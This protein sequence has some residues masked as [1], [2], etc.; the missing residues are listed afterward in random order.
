MKKQLSTL[1]IFCVALGAMAQ[2]ITND[3]H[4]KYSP[5]DTVYGIDLYGALKDIPKPAT[6]KSVIVAVIDNGVDIKHPDLVTN[7]WTNTF[8]IPGNSV[9]DD[10][11]GYIDD[12]HGWD[13]LGNV[14]GD[15]RYDNL[16]M[17]R[18]LRELRKKYDGK[19]SKEI[20]KSDK[21]EYKS[22]LALEETFAKEYT[23]IEKNYIFFNTMFE[24]QST[25]LREMGKKEP[26]Y[27]ELEEFEPKSPEA[28][29]AR[30][31]TLKYCAGGMIE[32][33][34]IFKEVDNLIKHFETQ[35]KYHYNL[36]FDPR[37]FVGDDYLD[38]KNNKY[39]NNEVAG[40]EPDHGSHVGGII[41]ALRE[42]NLGMDGICPLVQLMV[43]RVVPDG[44]ERDKDVALAIRYAVDNGAKVINM[45]FGKSYAFNK[46]A[47]D[48]A[49]KY[50]ESKDVLIIHAAGNDGKDLESNNNFPSPF[51]TDG[52]NCKTWIEVGA[53]NIDQAPAVFSNY[54]RK[55]VNVFAPGVQIY[56]T[57]PDSSYER[58][59]GTSMAAPVVAGVAALI[60][61]YYP[62]LTAVQVKQAI[63]SSVI[64]PTK[65]YKKPGS[66]RKKTKYKKLCTTAGVVNAAAA[67]KA[68]SLMK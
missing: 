68:A 26:S 7:I 1:A 20:A 53:S 22:Y 33:K 13:F 54:G 10:H 8:E 66:R 35:Y 49:V 21:A 63:E 18:K 19:S 15:I 27:K 9:D 65:K 30:S 14:S 60:R 57:T 56:S 5:K 42:N 37:P 44:D 24:Q 43:L 61:A 64:K 2:T 39:G 31:N 32:P 25:L 67:L 52:S 62:N 48:E 12:I 51:Y 28:K 46:A 55:T 6:A 11:N 40:P 36:K 23:N 17:T 4:L 34:V 29:L 59:D 50:A 47:V 58:F 3:W 41:G 38:P 45:S 16:E